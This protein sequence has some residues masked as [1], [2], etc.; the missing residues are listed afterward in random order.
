[1]AK[2]VAPHIITH[3]ERG[4]I[5]QLSP[6]ITNKHLIKF[7][8]EDHTTDFIGWRLMEPHLIGQTKFKHANIWLVGWFLPTPQQVIEG[9]E[10]K[11]GNYILDDV[12][13]LQILPEQFKLTRPLYNRNDSRMIK[14]FCATL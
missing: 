7:W 8:Y 13:Q 3:Y 9:R 6:A 1:M 10:A 11:W 12:K 5:T 4:L 2:E 14:I